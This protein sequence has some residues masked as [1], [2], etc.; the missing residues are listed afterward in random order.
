MKERAFRRF[1]HRFGRLKTKVQVFQATV[2][3]V[4]KQ[5]P[6]SKRIG[7]FGKHGLLPCLGIMPVGL[8]QIVKSQFLVIGS[9][10]HSQTPDDRVFQ[11]VD[12]L[13][14]GDGIVPIKQQ[15]LVNPVALFDAS[16]AFLKPI[17][18]KGFPLSPFETHP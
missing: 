4:F 9:I 14:L 16:Q 12:Q 2:V 3:F 13:L 15:P 18:F 7:G 17:D 8:F 1:P 10:I 5:I 11:M 6:S